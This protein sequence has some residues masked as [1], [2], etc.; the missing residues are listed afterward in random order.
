VDKDWDGFVTSIIEQ[1]AQPLRQT[2]QT[3]WDHYS[4]NNIAQKAAAAINNV[5]QQHA[6]N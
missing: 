6:A 1:A 3:F 4:W 2:P 5:K